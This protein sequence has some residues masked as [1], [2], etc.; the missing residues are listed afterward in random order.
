M[1][2]EHHDS[3]A[4]GRFDG[5]ERLQKYARKQR[6]QVVDYVSGQDAYTLHKRDSKTVSASSNVLEG[7]CR[8][9]SDRP[10]GLDEFV[11]VHRW[12]PVP[13]ELHR[14]IYETC[15]VCSAEDEDGSLSY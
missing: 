7:Y 5:V 3:L 1:G 12:V 15:M 11:D 6:K 8:P 2:F 9:I 10:D 4:P 13:A 14:R